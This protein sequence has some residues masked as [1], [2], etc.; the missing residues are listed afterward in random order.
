MLT[1]QK[2]I[3]SQFNT[4]LLFPHLL[5]QALKK[6]VL[7]LRLPVVLALSQMF[8]HR[9]QRMTCVWRFRWKVRGHAWALTPTSRSF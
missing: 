9:R 7:L 8:T 3:T 6:N 2:D 4:D 5:F 1:W